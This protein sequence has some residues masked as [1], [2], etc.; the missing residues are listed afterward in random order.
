MSIAE[1]PKWNQGDYVLFK[2]ACL[3]RIE[4]VLTN[5]LTKRV[6]Y[7]ATILF[8]R[9]TLLRWTRYP[10]SNIEFFPTSRIATE[11]VKVEPEMARLLYGKI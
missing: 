1:K 3:L 6:K 11:G 5:K 4:K 2:K 9:K 7:K 8:G 10:T